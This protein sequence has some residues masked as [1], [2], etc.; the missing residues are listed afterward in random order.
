MEA[1]LKEKADQLKENAIFKQRWLNVFDLADKDK[2]G[3]LTMDE[4]MQYAETLKQLLNKS[5][6]DIG[7]LRKAMAR[8]FK[9][10]IGDDGDGAKR[11]NWVGNVSIIAVQELERIEK[12][13][14]T[15][16][17]E[18]LN[19]FFGL[20]DLNKDNTLSQEEFAIFC[21]CFEWPED[22]V[23]HFFDVADTN[24]NG[25]LEWE[26]FYN[27]LFSFWYKVEEGNIENLFGGHL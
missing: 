24:K 3:V 19:I 14:P 4:V 6:E 17:E 10:F 15:E 26:E 23:P 13:E 22:M 9:Q 11:E 7:P 2:N 1:T 21:K 25:K 16:M 5:D 12:G 27:V 18:W 20:I 8:H